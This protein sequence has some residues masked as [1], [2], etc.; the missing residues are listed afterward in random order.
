MFPNLFFSCSTLH[1][2]FDAEKAEF[3]VQKSTTSGVEFL[4]YFAFADGWVFQI[5]VMRLGGD[6][7]FGL[8][9]KRDYSGKKDLDD[10][11]ECTKE[12]FLNA[13]DL[14]LQKFEREERDFDNII[15]SGDYE[16]A[17]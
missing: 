17:F 2:F 13:L 5:P 12:E 4:R 14:F 15:K 11:E 6:D 7:A 1:S 3:S 16:L 10:L 8:E 9:I